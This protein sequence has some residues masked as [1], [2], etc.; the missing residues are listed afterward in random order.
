MA[1]D[2]FI[3]YTAAD[4]DWAEWIAWEV[5]QAHYSTILQAWD[6][7]P[8]EDFV[9]EMQQTLASSERIIAVLSPSYMGSQLGEAEWRSAFAKDPTGELALLIPVRVGEV[10]PPGVLHTRLYIDLKEVRSFG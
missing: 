1:T 9:H 6:F 8:G 2:F 4:R 5:E 3:S 10:A 7:R